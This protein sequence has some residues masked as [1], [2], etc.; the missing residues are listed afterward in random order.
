M[1][2]SADITGKQ[3]YVLGIGHPKN[4]SFEAAPQTT[5]TPPTNDYAGIMA[6]YTA[7][8]TAGGGTIKLLP[9]TYNIAG[10]TLPVSSNIVYLGSG[11]VSGLQTMNGGP[12]T[13]GGTVIKGD[14]TSAAFAAKTTPKGAFDDNFVINAGICDLMISE[15]TYGIRVGS[16]DAG[17][18]MYSTLTNLK[19]I[20]CSNWG[21]FLMHTEACT[22]R[23]IKI[24]GC[25]NSYYHG[26]DSTSWNGGDSAVHDVYVEPCAAVAGTFGSKKSR[27]IWLNA[28]NAALNSLLLYQCGSNGPFQSGAVSVNGNATN[29]VAAITLSDTS[30]F[31]VG[32]PVVLTTTVAPFVANRTYFIKSIVTNASVQLCNWD[33]TDVFTGVNSAPVITPSATSAVTIATQGFA[34]I[35][36]SSN[37]VGVQGIT[38]V[39]LTNCNTEGAGT[40][41][42]LFQGS[43]ACSISG[44]EPNNLA[45]NAPNL[46]AVCLRTAES[47]QVNMAKPG[48][49]DS[50]SF[51]IGDYASDLP[52][53]TYANVVGSGAGI[54]RYLGFTAGLFLN[55]Q[56]PSPAL[57]A[58]PSSGYAYF[59]NGVAL[60]AQAQGSGNTI[61]TNQGNVI[62]FSTGA[63]GSMTLPTANATYLGAPLI[64]CNPN[65]GVCTLNTTGGQLIVGLG[66]SGTS[67]A[68]AANSNALLICCFDNSV[69]R[70]ARIA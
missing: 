57:R 50:D 46:Y 33:G 38:G 55:A 53:N 32:M 54:R 30:S 41:R 36:A 65:A 21:I 43:S 28:K 52:N 25:R 22:I 58:D 1:A 27:S 29:G 10:N 16:T 31:E 59:G 18:L 51:W 61:N 42:Y 68:I 67:I 4:P 56:S 66:A 26:N 15:F 20:K 70:W 23:Q 40:A 9:I 24:H 62:T 60:V 17:G 44:G 39:H 12:F 8:I 48:L 13:E 7:A 11:W 37:G 45:F 34:G 63:G 6:A 2:G 5:F 19:I 69:Y 14:G 35:Q 47:M 3:N 49:V 64:V